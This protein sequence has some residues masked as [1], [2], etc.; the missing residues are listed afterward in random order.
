MQPWQKVQVIW[1]QLAEVSEVKKAFKWLKMGVWGNV[2]TDTISPENILN[3]FLK[4][5]FHVPFDLIQPLHRSN[6]I[7]I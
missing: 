5:L 6:F 4:C 2:S 7:L 3:T 1:T